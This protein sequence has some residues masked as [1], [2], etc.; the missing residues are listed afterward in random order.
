MTVARMTV[1]Q[2]PSGR[3]HLRQRCS[4]GGMA[5]KMRRVKLTEAQFNEL[6]PYP[7][8]KQCRC[9]RDF[10]PDDPGRPDEP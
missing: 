3:T 1:W 4:G 9:L 7:T 5:N 2:S 8:G 6:G 10:R